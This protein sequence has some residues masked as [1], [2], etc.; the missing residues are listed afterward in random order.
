[1]DFKEF[2]ERFEKYQKTVSWW[3]IK[4]LNHIQEQNKCAFVLKSNHTGKD[5]YGEIL[6]HQDGVL[7]LTAFCK[8]SEESKGIFTVG[9]VKRSNVWVYFQEV[10]NQRRTSKEVYDLIYKAA[11]YL[12]REYKKNF[13]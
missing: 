6:L 13:N 1:M 7:E 10:N 12:K 5:F 9:T 4:L 11:V 8:K 2:Y 3:N